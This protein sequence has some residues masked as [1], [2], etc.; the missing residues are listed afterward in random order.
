MTDVKYL[1]VS[2]RVGEPGSVFVPKQGINVEALLTGGFIVAVAVST[3]KP[4]KSR[5]VNTAP[6]E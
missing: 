4:S 6:E 1:V 5:K 3:A 2:H